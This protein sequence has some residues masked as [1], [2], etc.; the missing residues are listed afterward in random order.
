M[1]FTAVAD[2]SGGRINTGTGVTDVNGSVVDFFISGAQATASNGVV[3]QASV[4]NTAVTPSSAALTVSNQAL[5]ITIATSNT[6]SN[7]SET[8]YSKP[9]AVQVNDANGAAVANQVVTL[10]VSDRISQG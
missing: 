10:S 8:I 6:I 3:I 7:K 2:S 4:A 1:N 5:F 9:F